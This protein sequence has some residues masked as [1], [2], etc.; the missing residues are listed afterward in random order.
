MLEANKLNDP[1]HHSYIESL[2][3]ESF[4]FIAYHG[5]DINYTTAANCVSGAGR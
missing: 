5:K 2:F 3:S 1:V 4:E